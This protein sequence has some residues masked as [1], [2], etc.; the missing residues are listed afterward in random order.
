MSTISAAVPRTHIDVLRRRLRRR[1]YTL[2]A[3]DPT[4]R[5]CCACVVAACPGVGADAGPLVLAAVVESC[6]RRHDRRRRRRRTSGCGCIGIDTPEIHV[7]DGPPECFGPE[8]AGVHTPSLLPAGHAGAPRARRRRPRRLRPAARLRL[9]AR[10]RPVRQR[11]DPPPAATRRPLTI[12]PN[13][14][15]A[16]RFV[17]RPRSP[18]RPTASACGRPARA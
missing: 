16:A 12:E 13:H 10:R 4:V 18:P 6:R 17:P 7:E 14:A 11:G 3:A 2:N 1:Y 8:A 5:C 9:P 15:F